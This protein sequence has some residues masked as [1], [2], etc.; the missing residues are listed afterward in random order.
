MR[1]AFGRADEARAELYAR[2]AHFEDRDD[3]FAAPDAACD[4][5]RNVANFRQDFL[6][7]NR[8]ADGAD[9]RPLPCLR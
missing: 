2:R 1:D 6:R 8:S 3:G 4:K 7:Q 5:D 9:G